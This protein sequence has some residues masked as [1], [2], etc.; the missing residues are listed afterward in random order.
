[1]VGAIVHREAPRKNVSHP[2]SLDAIR[3][4]A[5]AGERTRLITPRALERCSL[6]LLDDLAGA[7]DAGPRR[8]ATRDS[9]S[10]LREEAKTHSSQHYRKMLL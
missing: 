10:P 2:I 5:A 9:R 6:F 1:M 3:G 7:L 8:Q 4:K